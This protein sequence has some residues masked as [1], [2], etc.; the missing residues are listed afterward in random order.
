MLK[1]YFRIAWRNLLRSR[2][3][4]LINVTGLATGFVCF[5]LI[6]RYVLDELHY[7]RYP[8]R[9]SDIYR[10]TLSAT[11]NGEVAVYPMVDNAVGEGMKAAY[12]DIQAAT[13]LTPATDYVRLG[14]RQFKETHL[15]FVDSN[16]LD[17]FSIPLLQGDERQALT[18]PYTM[19][20]S[21]AFARKYFGDADPVGQTLLVGIRQ[22]AYKITGLFD[23][24]PAASHF[25]EDALLSMATF[26][27][28]GGTWSNIGYYTYLLLDPKAD[29]SRLAARFP[30]LVARYVVPE[31]QHDMGVS[32]AEARK[33]VKDFVF[34][35]Q[36][37]RDIH[38]RSHTRYELEPGGDIRYVYIF[39][40]LAVFILLLACVN[41]TNLSTARAIKR[42][43][44]VGIRKVMGSMRWQLVRQFLAESVLLSFLAMVLA[45]ILVLLLRP[46]FNQLSGKSFR[47]ADLA[48]APGWLPLAGLVVLVGIL[49]G[50]YPAFF[51]SSFQ[52]IRVLKGLATGRSRK[53]ALRS[54][55]IVFQFVVSISLIFA[56]MVVYRQQA[57]MQHKELGY[58][59]DQVLFLSEGRLLGASQD[60]FR[61]QLLQDPRIIAVTQTRSVPGD[62]FMGGTEVYPRDERGNGKEIHINIFQVDYDYLRTLGIR[63]LQG[64]FFSRD[65]PADSS[66]NVV[67]NEAA[68]RQ[69]GWSG[70]NPVGKTLVRSGQ[71]AYHVVGVVQDFHYA[72]VREKIA[73]LMML[74]GNNRGGFAVKFR[75]ADL[76]GLLRDLKRTWDQYGPS[77]S[78][79]YTFLDDTYAALYA[80]EGRTQ[81]IFLV[82]TVVAI[83]VACLGLLGLSAYV[84]EQ[85]TREIGIR[86]VL[87]ASVGR[88]LWQVSREFMMLVG[89]AF[90]ISMPVSWW[91]MSH[92]LQDYAYR[93]RLSGWMAGWSGLLAFAIAGLTISFQSVRAALANPVKSLRTE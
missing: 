55:L 72:S 36:P 13:R 41:F 27:L 38:L 56:T 93:I 89:L 26:H 81:R 79:S 64:R 71:L 90:V 1:N 51:L 32:L 29:P 45:I 33:S 52:P 84:I 85:R 92:W 2:V 50:I 49:A 11:G 73:P 7:D 20:V 17:M 60:A 63:L 74:L 54:G 88:V 59:K 76:A 91:A 70:E 16:F 58:D 25:H 67:I 34:G 3:F 8:A 80:G 10:V 18:Q 53:S 66:Q 40:C 14:E 21:Q 23:Q 48:G 37:L 44:E 61:D 9:A 87:G 5:I 83:L 12:P 31:I 35:L 30:E 78:F 86:K 42:A 24:V 69:L 75:T 28:H 43:R 39:S 15:A 77:G 46:L 68:A 62:P 65:F 82:F 19:V 57:Y 4:S 6:A 47:A 22:V